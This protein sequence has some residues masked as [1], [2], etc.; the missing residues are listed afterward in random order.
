MAVS[1]R[2]YHAGSGG[3][4]VMAKTRRNRGVILAAWRRKAAGYGGETA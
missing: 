1:P 4:G 3:N 2:K